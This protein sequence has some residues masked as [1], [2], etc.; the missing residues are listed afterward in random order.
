[1]FREDAAW[2]VRNRFL[3]PD[4][5]QLVAAVR[6]GV[7]A[8]HARGVTAVHDKDGWIG[9][10]RC[11]ARLRDHGQLRLRVFQS[12][13][14]TSGARMAAKVADELSDSEWLRIG[15]LKAFADGTLGSG[16]ALTSD[17]R[18]TAVT[19]PAS[20]RRQ[21]AEAAEV[22]LPLAVHAIGDLANRHVLDA[23]EATRDR[24][25]PADLTQRIEHAQLLSRTDVERM[26]ELGIVASVQFPQLLEDRS[27][28]VPEGVVHHA[29]RTMVAA[30]VTLV[31]GSDCPID[32]LDPIAALA[33]G[34]NGTA[35]ER[36]PWRPEERLSVKEA[37]RAATS[38]PA[39]LEGCGAR[40]GRIAPGC[41][42]DLV[43]LDADPFEVPPTSLGAITVAATMVGGR[44]VHDLYDI[45]SPAA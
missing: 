44:W 26:A 9:I 16:T 40:R 34:V 42:G 43:V 41:L 7:R 38:V 11:W 14:A 36:P 22:G 3:L 25:Q 27:Y 19:S 17:G 4:M 30:G 33:A 28:D 15:Y 18:G 1:V 39:W 24:W 37:L 6:D 13:P 2:R 5:D 29:H 8:A 23:F 20:L 21:I 10:H 32:E 45:A 12:L 31:S 35:D